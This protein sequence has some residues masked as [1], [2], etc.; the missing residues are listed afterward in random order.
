MSIDK[1]HNY[2]SG[3]EALELWKKGHVAWNQWFESVDNPR[4]D[5]TGV[6]FEPNVQE[7]NGEYLIS[8]N[9]YKLPRN[10]TTFRNVV[11][12]SGHLTFCSVDSP[13]SSVLFENCTIQCHRI[14]INDSNLAMLSFNCVSIST[15]KLHIVNSKIINI[16]V[17]NSKLF[18]GFFQI[19]RMTMDAFSFDFRSNTL[20]NCNFSLVNSYIKNSTVRFSN[21][22][23]KDGELSILDNECDDSVFEVTKNEFN[24]P[25]EFKNLLRL[26]KLNFQ[27]STFNGFFQ[28]ENI[29][30]SSVIDL[31]G[32][33][34]SNSIVIHDVE[35]KLNRT[36]SIKNLFVRIAN[37]PKDHFRFRRLKEI[38][39]STKDFELALHYFSNEKKCQRWI[40]QGLFNSL[41]DLIYSAVSNYGQS[42]II[43]LLTWISSMPLFALLYANLLSKISSEKISFADAII[44]SLKNSFPFLSL[45]KLSLE[46]EIHKVMY[47]DLNI[48]LIVIFQGVLSVIF[49][50][51]IGLG[52][53]NNFRI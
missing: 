9:R 42:I 36:R 50:F 45:S 35:N 48:I 52:L 23:I 8:F 17:F 32:T 41:I 11:F 24:C 44:I 13:E 6:T 37:D 12:K 47:S 49:T 10:H 53:R 14:S 51:L 16:N 27:G 22:K 4:I 31:T 15:C 43:P 5:F 19:S 34:I 29:S 25:L 28:L 26:K 33:K 1:R 46:T 2:L 30:T 21:I 7:P 18:D 20:E 40:N 3:N 38:A 39:E